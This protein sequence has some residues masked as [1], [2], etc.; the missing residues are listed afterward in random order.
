M[1]TIDAEAVLKAFVDAQ[2]IARRVSACGEEHRAAL[3]AGVHYGIERRLGEPVSEGTPLQDRMSQWPK[4]SG[5]HDPRD[6]FLT[7]YYLS[8]SV[9]IELARDIDANR[10]VKSAA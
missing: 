1:P 9:P 5:Q 3:I 8:A 6:A 2:H 4:D 10:V 7:G